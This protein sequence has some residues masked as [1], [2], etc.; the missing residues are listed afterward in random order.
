MNKFFESRRNRLTIR[1]AVIVALV[2]TAWLLAGCGARY[3]SVYNTTTTYSPV[4]SPSP[5]PSPKG[6]CANL[7][8]E[9]QGRGEEH[10]RQP[11]SCEHDN[12]Q[13]E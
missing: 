9:E 13:D 8:E 5:T 6:K 12:D 4:I 2:V 11:E 7:K 1:V 3:G 10:D